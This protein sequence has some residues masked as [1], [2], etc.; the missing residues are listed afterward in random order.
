MEDNIFR[1]DLHKYLW[2]NYVR[3][4]SDK[5]IAFNH[6]LVEWRADNWSSNT[7]K[8]FYDAM[9][10]NYCFACSYAYKQYLANLH[11]NKEDKD[12]CNFCPLTNTKIHNY[13][14]CNG[15]YNQYVKLIT[16]Q[17][18]GDN[19]EHLRRVGIPEEYKEPFI[20][21]RDNMESLFRGVCNAI[22]EIPVN[23]GVLYMDVDGKIKEAF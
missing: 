11:T 7:E 21:L 17:A 16:I 4:Y 19:I 6:M 10:M 9:F 2:I 1:Y 18:V 15:L 3:G 12:M 14:C 8:E 20:T 5:E 13:T 23:P 22:A